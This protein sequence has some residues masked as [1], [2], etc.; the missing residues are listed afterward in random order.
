[1]GLLFGLGQATT[2][3]VAVGQL[4]IA[5]IFGLGQ[6]A[7]GFVAIGQVGIGRYVL[8]QLGF[9]ENVWDMRRAS[10]VAQQFFRAMLK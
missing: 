2:G 1:V 8:A 10:P 3:M 6:I 7:T 9:G 5:G 4:A